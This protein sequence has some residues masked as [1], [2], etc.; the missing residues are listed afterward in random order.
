M[1]PGHELEW[2]TVD[3][4]GIRKSYGVTGSG[5]PVV[6]VHGLAASGRWWEGTA[7]ALASEFRVHVLDLIGFGG[8]WRQEFRLSD[9][10][11]LIVRWMEAIGL[12]RASFVGHS[13]GGHVVADLASR[14]PSRVDRLVLV[15]AAGLPLG[16]DYVRHAF[17]IVLTARFLRP[18]FLARIVVDLV[19]AGPLT[20]LAAGR[21]IL[22]AD[23]RR[24]LPLI[25]APTLV[26][27]G[28]S[29]PLISVATG[30]RLA[31]AIPGARFEAIRGA[32]HNPMWDRP[33][34]FEAALRRFLRESAPPPA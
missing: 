26:L 20:I 15:N 27:W 19:R 33:L 7:A 9:A 28:A 25:A 6:L 10:A 31:A 1:T 5:A 30:R 29:D 8:S 17:N 34:E 16:R 18:R 22:R 12:E 13:L 14:H 23:L 24:R 21:Q 2:G 4:G 32:G 3:L 11:S